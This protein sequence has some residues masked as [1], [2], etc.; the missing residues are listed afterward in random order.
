MVTLTMS[1]DGVAAF[2]AGKYMGSI[3]NASKRE[4]AHNYFQWI[5]KGRPAG[6]E[7]QRTLLLN[8]TLSY[9]AAQAVRNR[10]EEIMR[11]QNV[12]E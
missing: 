7:P 1:P 8:G 3:R 5:L 9:M 2:N 6:K 12:E 10:L 11:L 4:Y